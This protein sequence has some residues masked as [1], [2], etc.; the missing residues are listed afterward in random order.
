MNNTFGS[1]SV[2]DE[3]YPSIKLLLMESTKV[4]FHAF[5]SLNG[6]AN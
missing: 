2:S 5:C 1:T 3:T 6:G 4:S